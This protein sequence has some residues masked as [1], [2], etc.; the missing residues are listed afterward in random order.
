MSMHV[1][2]ADYAKIGGTP[3]G[4]G[5]QAAFI[6]QGMRSPRV[7][8]W[9][10][11]AIHAAGLPRASSPSEQASALARA[12]HA[13]SG[14]SRDALV[15]AIYDAQKRDVAFVNDPEHTEFIAS[16]EAI[17][18]L[19]PEGYCL[20]GGDCDDQVV[21]LGAALM[22]AGIPV[23]LVLRDY[24][25]L[26]MLHVMLQYDADLLKRGD[27]RCFD[28]SMETGACAGG[29]DQE[30]IVEVAEVRKMAL[31][32]PTQFMA[33]GQPPPPPQTTGQLSDEQ[34]SAWLDLLAKGQADLAA[35]AVRLR[36]STATLTKVRTALG[37]PS[38]DGPPPPE[39]PGVSNL[40]LASYVQN[41]VWTADA[42]AAESKLLQ[43]ADFLSTVMG[44]GL[45]GKRPLYWNNGDLFVAAKPG[46]P[47]GVLMLPN[48]NGA[49]V[50]T[51][52]D[53]SSNAP[54]RQ[55]GIAPILIGIAIVAVSLA[56]AYAV[57]KICDYMATAHRDDAMQKIAT[58]QQ[59]LIAAGKET[60]EQAK[61]ILAA[62]SD[63]ASAPPPGAA[64]AGF[65][66]WQ[67]LAAVTGSV[68]AGLLVGIVGGRLMRVAA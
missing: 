21:V 39:A 14:E 68:A 58:E 25:N 51:W 35:S 8:E 61:A 11:Q 17:L 15:R 18:C 37:L 32:E 53:T 65:T 29:Y 66:V 50:P 55:I 56:A 64:A 7:I 34:A 28:P 2:Q 46:D 10:R 62:A 30:I 49:L 33:M 52:V 44:E 3:R 41:Y 24:P 42:Q 59:A 63:L 6:L 20:R 26:P 4:L 1:V 57:T 23:R 48:P 19:D 12:E 67:L 22:S 9:T 54:V 5:Q 43:T 47:F 38:S 27:W 36:Q 16:A 40:P 60:P 31:M 13:L 45:S